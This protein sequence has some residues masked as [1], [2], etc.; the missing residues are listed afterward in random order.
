MTRSDRCGFIVDRPEIQAALQGAMYGS[1]AI[2]WVDGQAGRGKTVAVARMLEEHGDTPMWITS[3]R[4]RQQRGIPTYKDTDARDGFS[5]D[6]MRQEMAEVASCFD[7]SL[8]SSMSGAES[9]FTEFLRM[10]RAPNH[11]VL[12]NYNPE[13]FPQIFEQQSSDFVS[14]VTVISRD[15]PPDSIADDVN[16]V[17][18]GN[19]A[20]EEARELIG[21]YL[22]DSTHE[23]RDQLAE[24]WSHRAYEI[25][26]RCH[27][28]LKTSKSVEIDNQLHTSPTF[29]G[30]R[31]IDTADKKAHRYRY[32]ARTIRL[33]REALFAVRRGY[34]SPYC[35]RDSEATDTDRR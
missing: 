35:H 13:V 22:P 5:S 3:S 19:L 30:E 8:A 34:Q 27:A 20:V 32:E 11:V 21:L 26:E 12:D 4:M 33:A 25:D 16:R 29:E 23:Q 14:H 31:F 6:R 24:L 10:P 28:I 2:T 15:P 9:R 17:T 1:S 18:V 7:P